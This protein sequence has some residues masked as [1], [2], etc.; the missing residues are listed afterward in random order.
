MVLGAGGPIGTAISETLSAA[1][2]P[3]ISVSRTASGPGAFATDRTDTNAILQIVAERDVSHIID[4]IAYTEADTL[5]L[6]EAINGKIERYVMLSSADV[7]RNYGLLHQTETGDISSL[8]TEDAPL[9]TALYPYQKRQLRADEDPEKWMDTYDKIPLEAAVR[10]LSI[11]WTI[12]RLPM[13]YGA[14]GK[15][16]RFSWIAGP[17]KAGALEITISIDWYNWTT[18]YGHIRNVAA[19][20]VHAALHPSAANDTFNITDHAELAHSGWIDMFAKVSG[21]SGKIVRNAPPPA[22]IAALDLS[23]PLIMRGDKFREQ[24]GFKP[25]VSQT[26]AILDVLDQS[27]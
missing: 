6:L 14:S 20:I 9:R 5:P 21:W 7:Y 2:E 23:V 4:I 15:L 25:P 26:A 13:V 11:D 10:D 8:L 18:T 16:A 3:H 1:S 22:P 19:A 17:M 27:T 24:T 12:L